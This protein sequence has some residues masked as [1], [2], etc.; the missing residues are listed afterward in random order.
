MGLTYFI[1]YHL[2]K[3]IAHTVFSL[4]V[5]GRENI[6]EEGPVLLAMNHQSVLDPPFAGICCRREIHFLARKT[7]FEVPMLGPLLRRI[8][9]IGVDREGSDMSAIKTDDIDPAEKRSQH[10]NLE[11][12][13]AG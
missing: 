8:N 11:E 5:Y 12:R 3:F 6:I 2:S 4:R 1:G 7:L 13:L 10:R 9:V